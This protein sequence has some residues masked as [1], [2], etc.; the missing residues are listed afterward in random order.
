MPRFLL[1]V[2]ILTLLAGCFGGRVPQFAPRRTPTAE[3]LTAKTTEECRS[4]HEIGGL[5]RHSI[6]DDCFHC[7]HICRECSP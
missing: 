3:H 5:R 7:H 4:C 1:L 6:K 2:L